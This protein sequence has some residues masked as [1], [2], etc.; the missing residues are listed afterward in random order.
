M[1]VKRVDGWPVTF[2]GEAH[3]GWLPSNAATPLPTPIERDV[4]DVTIE[5][6]DAGY[7]L[8]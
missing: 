6:I 4:L 1:V 5:K 7:L 2:G 8:I 3:S